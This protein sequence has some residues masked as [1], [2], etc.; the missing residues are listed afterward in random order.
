MKLG[1]DE[2]QQ[3]ACP[4][5]ALRMTSCK[6]TA[7]TGCQVYGK[8]DGVEC[9]MIVDT[10]SE[11]TLVRPD[12]LSHRRLPETSRRVSGVT[13]HSVELR[14]PVDVTLQ[15]GDKEESLTVYVADIEDPCI[16][17]MDYLVSCR[18][19]LDFCTRRR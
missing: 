15:L 19:E 16:L 13:G 12:V 3:A 9:T 1:G 4:V 11:K 17:G 18:C 2:E 8:I 7:T 14:G 6:Q 5:R 10:G